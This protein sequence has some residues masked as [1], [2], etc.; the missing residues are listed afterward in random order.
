M[1]VIARKPVQTPSSGIAIIH[2]IIAIA[3]ERVLR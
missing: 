1:G 3:I 2:D